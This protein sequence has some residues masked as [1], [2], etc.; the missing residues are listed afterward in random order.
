MAFVNEKISDEDRK[1]YGIDELDNG[2]GRNFRRWTIDREK[3]IFLISTGLNKESY[4]A[5]WVYYQKSLS[6]IRV[7]E[8]FDN[9]IKQNV[10]NVE[11]RQSISSVHENDKDNLFLIVKNILEEEKKIFGITS[12]P[13]IFRR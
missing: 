4:K 10:F 7:T 8:V 11:G 3:E 1:T 6:T 9:R 2:R 13:I 12:N 5:F